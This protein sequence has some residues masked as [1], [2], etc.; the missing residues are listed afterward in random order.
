MI[1]DNGQRAFRTSAPDSARTSFRA[2]EMALLT[3]DFHNDLIPGWRYHVTLDIE[4]GPHRV[5]LE[6]RERVAS[7]VVTG[8]RL[9]LEQQELDHTI[10]VEHERAPV[11]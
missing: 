1:N 11:A 8:A 5:V 2:G 3:L 7:I 4:S 9:V 10:R 6:R